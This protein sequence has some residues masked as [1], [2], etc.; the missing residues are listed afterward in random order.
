M[1]F[2]KIFELQL[3]HVLGASYPVARN[4]VA[5]FCA[6]VLDDLYSLIF[7]AG[8]KTSYNVNRNF[9]PRRLVDCDSIAVAEG[10]VAD[11]LGLSISGAVPELSNG[12]PYF[13][14]VKL[15]ID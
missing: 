10:R 8:W 4:Q 13:K 5:D 1:L 2:P 11:W 6:T 9:Q 7:F 15:P 12:M 14:R 3:C